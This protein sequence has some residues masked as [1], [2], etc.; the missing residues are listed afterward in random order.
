MGF[1]DKLFGKKT[2]LQEPVV[3]IKLGAGEL[4]AVLEGEL[5]P[6]TASE[7]PVF[8]Q[9]LMG[10]GYLIEPTNNIVV[11]PVNGVIQTVFPTKHALGILSDSGDEVIIHVGLDTVKLNGE[12]FTAFVV[13]G[14]KVVAG[15]K[16]LEVDFDLIRSKVPSI[17]TPVVI[18]NIGDRKV[19]LKDLKA[20]KAGDIVAT[21]IA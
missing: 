20:V 3:A 15:Q 5:K 4:A 14:D 13:A 10:D 12:G 1:L 17:A 8:S 19:E 6:L 11:S 9:K 21:I 16:L 18:S 2:E 7:D